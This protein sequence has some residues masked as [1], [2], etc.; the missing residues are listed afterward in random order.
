MSEKIGIITYGENE[1]DAIYTV[2]D[3]LEKLV[4]KDL[5]EHWSGDYDIFKLNSSEARSF[6]DDSIK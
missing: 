6:I 2:E 5:I 1:V 3:L 4:E